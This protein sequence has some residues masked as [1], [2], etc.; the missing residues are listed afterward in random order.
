VGGV[1]IGREDTRKV[2]ALLR[3]SYHCVSVHYCAGMKLGSVCFV[4]TRGAGVS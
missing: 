2:A 3:Y 1:R 4:W